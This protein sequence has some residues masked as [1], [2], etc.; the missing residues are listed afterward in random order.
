[1]QGPREKLVWVSIAVA[2]FLVRVESLFDWRFEGELV[3]KEVKEDE[4]GE[5]QRQTSVCAVSLPLPPSCPALVSSRLLIDPSHPLGVA[6][7][8]LSLAI[9]CR[10][11]G[12]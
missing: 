3:D 8:R 6:R 10:N 9:A 2:W 5:Q 7:H 4:K 12:R 1:M 11:Y